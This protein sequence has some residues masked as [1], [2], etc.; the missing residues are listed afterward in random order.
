MVDFH[1]ML[2]FMFYVNF[3]LFYFVFLFDMI[4]VL[5]LFYVSY[6]RQNRCLTVTFAF[7]F[8]LAFGRGISKKFA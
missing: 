4:Y 8:M 7:Y 6:L 3:M 2:D 5:C 1:F